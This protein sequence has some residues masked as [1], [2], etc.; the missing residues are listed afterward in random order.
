MAMGLARLGH[1]GR[2]RRPRRRGRVRPLLPRPAGGPRHRHLARDPGRRPRR[3]ASPSSITH[4]LDRALV[5][6]LGA[7]S[8]LTGRDV[9]D[10]ARWPASTTC[11][12]P[13]SSSRRGCGRTS[14][15]SSRA[16]TRAG[17]TTSLDT[18]Y[19]S[20]EQWDGGLRADARAHGPL[21]P[22]RGRAARRSPAATTRSTACG[23]C[24]TAARASSR[25]SAREG[26]MTLEKGEVAPRA[27][28]PG[29]DGGHDRAPATPSTPA[30]C[31]RGCS[32]APVARLP[33]ARA[34]RAGRSARSASA[35]P[36]RSRR[37]RRPRRSC[38]GHGRERAAPAT[39][40]PRAR[41]CPAASAATAGGSAGCSSPRPSSTTSTARRSTSSGRRLK[42]EFHWSNQDF[43]LIIIAFRVAYTV[44]QTVGGRIL[45]RLGTRNGLTRDGA[46][47]LGGGQPHLA[48]QRAVELLRLPLPARR[49]RG[50]Q[51]AGGHEGRLRVVPATPARPGGGP[52]RQ[53]LVGR[54][55]ARAGAACSS[56]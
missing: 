7:I 9:P 13:P 34:P 10:R 47:V 19:D 26:A 6:Y 16:R 17:L 5:T 35:A 50:R 22:E 18:G 30:S 25:S 1:A 54:R 8:A 31:T 53:R 14:P 51:L 28:V 32:G 45:D 56:W 11:T 40:Q 42:T 21:L 39:Q 3:P 2:V 44:M 49:G 48:R 46:V 37:S 38:S 24:A 41:R 29:G 33:A 4:P 43:A 27:G 36:A 15:T 23:G 20:H 12:P 55:D 52:L